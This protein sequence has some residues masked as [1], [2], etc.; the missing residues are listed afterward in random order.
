[1]TSGTIDAWAKS[2]ASDTVMASHTAFQ[3]LS[4]GAEVDAGKKKAHWPV[5]EPAGYAAAR[6]A[7]QKVQL[8]KAGARLAQLLKGIWP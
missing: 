3:G 6:A 8:V 7:L 5:T 1:M 4:F 2:W